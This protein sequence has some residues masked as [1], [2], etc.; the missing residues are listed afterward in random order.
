MWS[1]FEFLYGW[2]NSETRILGIF[3]DSMKME[4]SVSM[5]IVN[6]ISVI[7]QTI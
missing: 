6:H 3:Y 1:L 5:E 2:E 7:H 4:S